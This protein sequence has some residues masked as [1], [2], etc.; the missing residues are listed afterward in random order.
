MRRGVASQGLGDGGGP[1]RRV[2]WWGFCF[3]GLV[4]FVVCGCVPMDY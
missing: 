2:R 3:A 4:V 1:S